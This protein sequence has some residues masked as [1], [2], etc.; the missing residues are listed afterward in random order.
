MKQNLLVRSARLHFAG[1]R[2]A[3]RPRRLQLIVT[4]R[5]VGRRRQR[6]GHWWHRLWRIGCERRDRQRW[7]PGHRRFDAHRCRRRRASDGAESSRDP[8]PAQGRRYTASG[9]VRPSGAAQGRQQPVAELRDQD[10]PREQ[11]GAAVRARPLEAVGDPRGHGRRRPGGL[12]RDRCA[13]QRQQGGDA[14]QGEHHHPERHRPR[15]LRDRRLAHQRGRHVDRDHPEH[16]RFR[17]LHADRH[18]VRDLSQRDLRDLQRADRRDLG[19]DQAL[20]RGGGGGDPRRRQRQPDR[21][22]HPELVAGR[23][24]GGRRVLWRGPTCSTRF[25]STPARTSSP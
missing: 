22:R 13:D 20:S 5:D 11:A 9:S 23:R 14:G 21:A 25:I 3:A 7:R 15:H 18:P 8:R 16:G 12:S 17:L 1:L 4:R 19:A 24:S 2:I 10:L 6:T